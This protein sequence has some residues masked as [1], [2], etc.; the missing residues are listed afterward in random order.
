MTK[1]PMIFHMKLTS[2]FAF[3]TFY[4]ISATPLIVSSRLTRGMMH[5]SSNSVPRSFEIGSFQVSTCNGLT[6]KATLRLYWAAH[7]EDSPESDPYLPWRVEKMTLFDSSAMFL[8][9]SLFYN[10][11]HLPPYPSPF[12]WWA[13]PDQPPDLPMASFH[14]EPPQTRNTQH[15]AVNNGGNF[16]QWRTPTLQKKGCSFQNCHFVHM[17]NLTVCK[18][19]PK[20]PANDRNHTLN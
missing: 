13:F 18:W 11:L 6:F 7:L 4:I 15:S 16:A 2:G 10:V 5:P 20:S 12:N 3:Q 17:W 9:L 14:Q 19:F 1:W 8:R